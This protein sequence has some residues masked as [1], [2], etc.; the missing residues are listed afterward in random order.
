MSMDATK[1]KATN[2]TKVI[3]DKVQINDVMW[4]DATKAK[5]TK[6]KAIQDKRLKSMR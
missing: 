4:M 1:A 3:Q 2:A 5:A 6:A